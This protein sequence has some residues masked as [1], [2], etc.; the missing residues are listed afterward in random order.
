MLDDRHLHLRKHT[1]TQIRDRRD[2][3]LILITQGNVQQQ[4]RVRA[5]TRAHQLLRHEWR[6]FEGFRK[7]V[8]G[9]GGVGYWHGGILPQSWYTIQPIAPTE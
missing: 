5:H 3:R 9:C 1:Q 4:V 2:A 8:I 6:D 7:S